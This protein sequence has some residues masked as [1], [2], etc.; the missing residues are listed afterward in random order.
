[1]RGTRSDSH[2][3]AGQ[4]RVD[5]VDNRNEVR[6]SWPS[7]DF[8]AFRRA[9]LTSENGLKLLATWLATNQQLE[10]PE[11]DHSVDV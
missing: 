4:S 10:L 11:S 7:D 9:R 3:P 2:L 5:V 6:D 8:L 1:V